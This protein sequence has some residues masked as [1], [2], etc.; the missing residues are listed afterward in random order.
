MNPQQ[1]QSV[2][3]YL[4]AIDIDSVDKDLRSKVIRGAV[5]VMTSPIYNEVKALYPMCFGD[6]KKNGVNMVDP[7]GF[8]LEF[9]RLNPKDKQ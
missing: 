1:K 5:M 7:K 3:D 4:E 2:R 9:K 8:R 6:A